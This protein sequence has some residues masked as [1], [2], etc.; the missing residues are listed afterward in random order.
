MPV[1]EDRGALRK[2]LG[3]ALYLHEFLVQRQTSADGRVHYG[4]AIGYAWIRAHWP[5]NWIERPSE[6][7]LRRWMLRLKLAHLVSVK[8]CL[9]HDGIRVTMVGSVKFAPAD[10]RRAEQLPLL[11]GPLGFPQI[12]RVVQGTGP[13]KSGRFVRPFL[14]A[15][16]SKEKSERNNTRA[17]AARDASSAG[18]EPPYP[19]P[20]AAAEKSPD[21]DAAAAEHRWR[22]GQ[23][24][25]RILREM[26]SLRAIYAGINVQGD[27]AAM[28]RRDARWSEL[29]EQL[30]STGWQ[31]ERAG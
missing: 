26:D 10:R 30:Q 23:K 16:R 20:A 27:P 5:G 3:P 6:R 18:C 17:S 13:A 12:P 2:Q 9:L 4:H 11:G 29:A 19:P 14:A 28:A 31:D 7:T 15:Q 1:A 8:H 24:A 22:Q 25:R 21:R